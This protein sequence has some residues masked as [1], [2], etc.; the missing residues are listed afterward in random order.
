LVDASNSICKWMERARS[1]IQP[2]LD[3]ESPETDAPS[4]SSIVTAIADP[5]DLQRCTGSQFVSQWAQKNISD[6]HKEKRKTY[7]MRPK[8]QSTRLKRMSV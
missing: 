1:T 3:E 2:E 5:R 7:A 6:S 8:S 4:P